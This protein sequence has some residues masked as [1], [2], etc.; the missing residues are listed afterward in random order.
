MKKE[1]IKNA[2]K[3]LSP[4]FGILFGWI[5]SE[6]SWQNKTNTDDQKQLTLK[7]IELIVILVHIAQMHIKK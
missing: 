6:I 5:L 2:F 4:F 1:Q 3:F 7:K